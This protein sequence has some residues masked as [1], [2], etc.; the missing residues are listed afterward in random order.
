MSIRSTPHPLNNKAK[1][2]SE[3]EIKQTHRYHT[4]LLDKKVFEMKKLTANS[5]KDIMGGTYLDDRKLCSIEPSKFGEISGCSVHHNDIFN[6]PQPDFVSRISDDSFSSQLFKSHYGTINQDLIRM[7]KEEIRKSRNS[8]PYNIVPGLELKK[9]L[10]LNRIDGLP[11]D[12]DDKDLYES[13]CHQKYKNN[14][15]PQTK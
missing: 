15:F 8:I 3:T 9:G 2:K 7:K 13:Y 4:E 12:L 11:E 10:N 1:S 6:N 14:L 5:G